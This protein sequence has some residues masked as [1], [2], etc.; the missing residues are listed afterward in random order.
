M[1]RDGDSSC[2]E[3]ASQWGLLHHDY[4]PKP[5]FDV[6]RKLIAEFGET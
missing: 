3:I 5:A 1:L 6:Y 4:S 2:P